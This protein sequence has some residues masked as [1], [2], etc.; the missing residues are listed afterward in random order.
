MLE[1]GPAGEELLPGRAVQ[2][3]ASRWREQHVAGGQERRGEGSEGCSAGGWGNE[4]RFGARGWGFPLPLT[5][6]S[7]HAGEWGAGEDWVLGWKGQLA[8]GQGTPYS[9]FQGASPAQRDTRSLPW[10]LGPSGTGR[11]PGD[12]GVP[13]PSPHCLSFSFC[14]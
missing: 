6:V 3:R 8:H 7:S 2:G 5:D 14:L 12:S 13:H 9:L 11:C 1:L 10:D 4:G